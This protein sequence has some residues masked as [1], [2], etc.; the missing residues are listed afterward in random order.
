[1]SVVKTPKKLLGLAVIA[2][3]SNTTSAYANITSKIING[4]EAATKEVPWQVYV[5]VHDETKGNSSCGGVVLNSNWILTAAHCVDVSMNDS[6]Y[7]VANA[8]DVFVGSGMTSLKDNDMSVSV[9]K[10]V[11]IHPDYYKELPYKDIALIQLRYPVSKKATAIK[12]LSLTEQE[13]LDLELDLATDSN[14]YAS[15]WGRTSNDSSLED[16]KRLNLQKTVLTGVNDQRCAQAW[17][18]DEWFSKFGDNYVC[19]NSENAGVCNGDSGGPLVWQ[20]KSHAADADK[21]YRLV[22]ITSFVHKSRCANSDYPDVFTQV[23]GSKEWI[24]E[25][26]TDYQEPNSN[27][28]FDIFHPEKNGPD[29]Q[30]PE[31]RDSEQKKSSSGGGSLG[32][33][34]LLLISLLTYTRR[35]KAC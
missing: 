29:V 9:A 13:A 17:G 28:V 32:Y 23:S 11:I 5:E 3:F 14:V 1:M 30:D 15:G 8:G 26:I 2:L 22:G 25:Q 21:G 7:N 33:L 18:L 27:F 20:D 16:T 10:Q 24:L 34:S 4:D 12:M 6:Y 19:A 35:R 31:S